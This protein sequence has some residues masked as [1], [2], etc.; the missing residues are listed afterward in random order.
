MVKKKYKE[1]F[2]FPIAGGEWDITMPPNIKGKVSKI[3]SKL[4]QLNKNPQL[5][6]KKH[7]LNSFINTASALE[8]DID[9]S[10]RIPSLSNK[11]INQIKH[12]FFTENISNKSLSS[13]LEHLKN[14]NLSSYDEIESFLFSLI[15]NTDK[16]NRI[17]RILKNFTEE[18]RFI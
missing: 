11:H 8:K 16:L 14:K 7:W 3:S 9:I 15:K 18:D 12:T 13:I 10:I 2:N 17:L 5:L 1:N 4:I 6:N